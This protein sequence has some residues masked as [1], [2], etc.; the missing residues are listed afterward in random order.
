VYAATRDRRAGGAVT[1]GKVDDIYEADRENK[2]AN[3]HM[4]PAGI[5]AVNQSAGAWVF[6]ELGELKEWFWASGF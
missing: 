6:D 3:A 5:V 2:I 1:G 4:V